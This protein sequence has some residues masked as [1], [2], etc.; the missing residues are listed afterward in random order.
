LGVFPSWRKSQ[1]RQRKA[2]TSWAKGIGKARDTGERKAEKEP[3]REFPGDLNGSL[4]GGKGEPMFD[5]LKCYLL[6]VENY[7]FIV[8]VIAVALTIYW[9]RAKIR[10]WRLETILRKIWQKRDKDI[11]YKKLQKINQ[12]QRGEIRIPE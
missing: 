10:Q 8:T 12:D 1:T 5:R 4:R 3:S 6:V 11:R 2:K 9:T 7:D